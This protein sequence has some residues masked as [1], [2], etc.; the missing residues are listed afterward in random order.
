MLQKR[1]GSTRVY[2]RRNE[3]FARNYVVDVENFGG[4][5]VMMW[6]AISYAE[7]LNWCTRQP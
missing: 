2:R 6:V 1:D 4:G 3:R 5:S 7:K